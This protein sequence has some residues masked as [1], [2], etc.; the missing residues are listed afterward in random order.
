[1]VGAGH[2]PVIYN[3]GTSTADPVAQTNKTITAEETDR[4]LRTQRRRVRKAAAIY[5]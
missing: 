5:V 3:V 4:V 1:M 2:T